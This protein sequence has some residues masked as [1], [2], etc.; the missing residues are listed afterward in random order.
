MKIFFYLSLLLLSL[1]VNSYNLSHVATFTTK[2]YND[3]WGQWFDKDLKVYAGSDGNN[4]NIRFVFEM[5]LGEYGLNYVF[6]GQNVME[7]SD[8]MDLYNHLLKAQEWSA[9][10]RN[11]SVETERDIG[12]CSTFGTICKVS[13]KSTNSGKNTSALIDVKEDDMWSLNEGKFM[14]P[15]SVLNKMLSNLKPENMNETLAI[16]SQ[17]NNQADDLFN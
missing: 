14:V 9:V 11:N 16:S 5:N 6:A 3:V 12:D 2:E 1:A 10:A 4:S 17:K 15:S 7:S 8:Y 13:F